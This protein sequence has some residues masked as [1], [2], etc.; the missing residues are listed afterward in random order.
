[1]HTSLLC[2]FVLT[3]LMF[4][5]TDSTTRQIPRD[6]SFTIYSAYRKIISKYPEAKIAERLSYKGV[7]S[8]EN[9]V[10]VSYGTRKLHADIFSPLVKSNGPFPGV[11]LIHGGGWRSGNK[12]QQNPMAE[13][14]A[15]RGYVAASVEYRLSMEALYPAS[16]LDIK[17]AVRWLRS[18]AIHY[19]LDT[20]RIAI[21]GCSAG[22]QLASLIGTTNGFGK[23]EGTIGNT[24]H[25]S[26]V[27]AIVN[28]D[29]LLDFTDVDSRKF[30]NDPIKPS[31][32]ALWFGG[33]FVAKPDV[34]KE[35]SPITYTNEHTPP[36]IFINSILPHYHAGRDNMIAILDAY[37]IYHEQY[38]I[39]ETPH[40]FWLFHP[41]YKPTIQ[42]ITDFLSK[43]FMIK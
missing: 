9:V 6:T 37:N 38:T 36:I 40:P 19:N 20:T 24:E 15:V 23:F 18:K 16:V 21:L 41:W 35:A 39:P 32:A 10:Y 3:G 34:W 28:I 14:L 5:Q 33:Q 25:S 13:E 2:L 11:I 30:D 17:A 29:G 43:V 31:A 27:Q 12:T 8:E 26:S 7:L 4:G 22:G 42:Y 1:M